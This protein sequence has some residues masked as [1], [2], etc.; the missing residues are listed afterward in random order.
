MQRSVNFSESM[1][2]KKFKHKSRR[3]LVYV[4]PWGAIREIQII[5]FRQIRRSSSFARLI[6]CVAYYC[7][8]FL[9]LLFLSIEIIY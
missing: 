8:V 5:Y 2:Q 7:V 6:K 1:K 9:C 3:V 4:K